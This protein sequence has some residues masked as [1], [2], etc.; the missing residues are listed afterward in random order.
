MSRCVNV[1]DRC[2]VRAIRGRW[3]SCINQNMVTCGPSQSSASG[4]SSLPETLEG[5]ESQARRRVVNNLSPKNFPVGDGPGAPR[6]Q[7]LLTDG[8]Y[9][10]A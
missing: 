5:S 10:R 6:H 4:A 1:A 9:T 8:L 2:A 3:S 7:N